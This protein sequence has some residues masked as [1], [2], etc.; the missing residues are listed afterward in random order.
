MCVCVCVLVCVLLSHI[1]WA[2]IINADCI[3]KW[4]RHPLKITK[5]KLHHWI[6]LFIVW[7]WRAACH[8]I[9]SRDQFPINCQKLSNFPKNVRKLSHF[10]EIIHNC[11]LKCNKSN[12]TQLKKKKIPIKYR[13]YGSVKAWENVKLAM[14]FQGSG[15]IWKIYF[16]RN[17]IITGWFFSSSLVK[18]CDFSFKQPPSN[19]FFLN[20]AIN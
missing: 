1:L 11:I 7:I 12:Q 20:V 9:W 8:V 18:T 4:A 14:S 2:I 10:P 5:C 13:K 15:K 17:K 19:I 3:N 16:S 6:L